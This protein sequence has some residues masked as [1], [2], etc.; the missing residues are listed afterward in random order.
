MIYL[1][2]SA[3]TCVFESAAEIMRKQMTEQY[4]NASATYAA[5]LQNERLYLEAKKSIAN[6]LKCSQNEVFFNS[7]GTEGA[8]T[9]LFGAIS[10]SN[11]RK[12][13]VISAIEHPA[14][15]DTALALK[16][17]GCSVSIAPVNKDG[18][19]DANVLASLVT[20]QTAIVSIMHINNEIG[21]INNLSELSKA[22][23]SVNPATL[24]HSD[25]VQ[26]YMHIPCD[27]IACGVDIYSV[28]AHK[29]HGSKGMGAMFIKEGTPMKPLI[30]GGGQQDNM[31]SGT[32]NM[33]GIAGMRAAVDTLSSMQDLM[34]K[35]SD[36]KNAYIEELKQIAECLIIGDPSK[37]APH[38]FN[39]AFKGIQ[40][41]VLQNAL[42][43]QGVIVGKGAACSSRT[44]K[45]SRV[46]KELEIQ[47]DYAAGAIRISLGAFNTLDEVKPATQII[48]DTVLRLR[49]FKRR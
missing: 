44:N 40:A 15:Y 42:E 43:E 8:N 24:F 9:A 30:Y 19:V 11:D 35:L 7:G 39:I 20:S 17:R 25:G 21:S 16:S 18:T 38:I 2:N 45:I 41:Q 26:A 1:D 10:A 3:T 49:K 5:A 32:L 36:I 12:H 47:A 29:I 37:T 46:L 33:P 22:V 48:K 34:P 13:I 4:F 6:S 27:V 31:R 23:K 14:V 28:S